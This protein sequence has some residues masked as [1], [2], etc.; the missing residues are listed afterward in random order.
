[1]YFGFYC[2]FHKHAN[3]KVQKNSCTLVPTVFRWHGK[4]EFKFHFHFSF[5]RDIE[6]RI[7]TSYFVFRFRIT[8]KN[9]SEFRF[10]F[11]FH[12]RIILKTDLDFVFRFRIT[13]KNGF[14]FRFSFSHHFEKRIWISL[15][16]FCMA[17]YW[18]ID[19]NFVCHFFM[20][21][22]TDCCTNPLIW[23]PRTP[24]RGWPGHSLFM[25]V[26]ASEFFFHRGQSE[27]WTPPA[28]NDISYPHG[29]LFNNAMD[30]KWYDDSREKTRSYRN[31]C[32]PSMEKENDEYLKTLQL[33]VTKCE[34]TKNYKWSF[35]VFLSFCRMTQSLQSVFLVVISR[36]QQITTS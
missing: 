26:K 4:M 31:T 3:S 17:C 8:L 15:F 34:I 29:T 20:T 23:S 12:F 19:L 7:W 27:W 28:P 16:P 33:E 30:D 13:L 5:S 14:E 21:W 24:P 11:V 10:N 18:K 9:G 6:K 22:K 35:T 1:M 32:I 25:Q 2:A 36:I